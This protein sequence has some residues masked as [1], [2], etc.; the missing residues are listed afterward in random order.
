M[1]TP[2]AAESGQATMAWVAAPGQLAA[3]WA[4]VLASDLD[5]GVLDTGV[6]RFREYAEENLAQIAAD[7][8][9]GGYEPGPLTR[10]AFPART[11]G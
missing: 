9:A 2:P 7:L 4:D 6:S 11:G 8:R 3:A 5:D 1:S 10:W